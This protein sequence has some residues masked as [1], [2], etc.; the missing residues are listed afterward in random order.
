MCDTSAFNSGSTV[1]MPFT[2]QNQSVYVPHELNVL[3]IP[4]IL[5]PLARFTILWYVL[6]L[7]VVVVVVVVVC[8]QNAPE[9]CLIAT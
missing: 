1:F 3:V 8:F 7:V 2:Q 6:A 5:K 9:S 4:C